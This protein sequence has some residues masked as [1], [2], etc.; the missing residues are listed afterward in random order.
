M[1]C[2]SIARKII[3]KAI[4]L[5]RHAQLNE[6]VWRKFN[7]YDIKNESNSNLQSS[8]HTF[9]REK[10]KVQMECEIMTREI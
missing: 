3:A 2:V 10:R 1:L 5:S 4:E 8:L 6:N 9:V 7:F